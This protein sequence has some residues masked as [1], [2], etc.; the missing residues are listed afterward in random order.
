M[1]S[2]TPSNISRVDW[3]SR[4]PGADHDH[5]RDHEARDR[6]EPAS[7]AQLIGSTQRCDVVERRCVGRTP[8][9]E[10]RRCRASPE[11]G[12]DLGAPHWDDPQARSLC[13][14]LDSRVASSALGRYRLLIILHGG[15]QL[16]PVRV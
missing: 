11:Y 6:I 9:R 5:E 4:P 10:A 7:Q 2:G 3:R 15:D 8:T 14:D 13:L 1:C 12:V 16:Q